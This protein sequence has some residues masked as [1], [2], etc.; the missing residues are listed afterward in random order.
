[1]KKYDVLVIAAIL[2]A[3]FFLLFHAKA[4]RALDWE[5]SSYTGFGQ[6]HNVDYWQN[7]TA[8]KGVD[9]VSDRGYL[10]F[11][12]DYTKYSFGWRVGIGGLFG[13]NFVELCGMTFYTEGYGGFAYYG[14]EENLN[15]QHT[16][17]LKSPVG[18]I[19]GAEL[20]FKVPVGKKA[21]GIIAFGYD[22]LSS[23]KSGDMGLNTFGP[24]I[25]LR[26]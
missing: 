21:Q 10:G 24:K 18:G 3:I 15:R 6:H 23:L 20:G 2:F 16:N 14:G 7:T 8:L 4:C 12:M 11:R 22:H 17:L 9:Y 13:Y 5:I 1:M 19:F 26:W 25:G